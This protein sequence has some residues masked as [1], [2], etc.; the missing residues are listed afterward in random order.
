MCVF[1]VS[2]D[3]SKL[4]LTKVQQYAVKVK[5]ISVTSQQNNQQIDDKNNCLYF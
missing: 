4:S 3:L 1:R 2:E 5:K